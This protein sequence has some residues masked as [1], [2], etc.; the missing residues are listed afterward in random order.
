MVEWQGQGLSYRAMGPWEELACGSH[1]VVW[2]DGMAESSTV[3]GLAAA[4][5]R[6]KRHR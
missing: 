1:G 3:V 4:S 5:V 2:V 6:D